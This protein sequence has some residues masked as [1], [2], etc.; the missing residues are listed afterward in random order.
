MRPPK[1][2]CRLWLTLPSLWLVSDLHLDPFTVTERQ[3]RFEE[4]LASLPI[5]EPVAI[6]GDL[7]DYWIGDDWSPAPFAS[8]WATFATQSEKRLILFQAGNR[9]FLAG[10]QLARRL[11]WR[12]LPPL[13]GVVIGK[14]RYL[15]TH[16]DALCWQEPD[17][18]AWRAQSRSPHWQKAFLAQPLDVRLEFAQKLRAASR[19]RRDYPE[20]VSNEAVEALLTRYPS[21]HL[22]HGHTHQPKQF[23]YRLRGQDKPQM[24][25]VLAEWREDGGRA[26]AR[27][28]REGF[29][30]AASA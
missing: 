16:G 27:L 4:W 20:D 15:L 24:R 11:G 30:R 22:I 18:L 26:V 17:Y 14:E 3:K 5:G 6:L 29:H 8:L 10:R 12:R 19:A 28:D 13:A 1:L 21:A 25:W 9:D 2:V 7:F 23:T